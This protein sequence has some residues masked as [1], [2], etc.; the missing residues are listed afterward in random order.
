MKN[1]SIAISIAAFLLAVSILQR[2]FPQSTLLLAARTEEHEAYRLVTCLFIHGSWLHVCVN[3][4]AF[5]ILLLGFGRR[6]STRLVAQ[7]FP[8]AL[9]AVWVYSEMLMPS[10][11]WLCGSSPLVYALFGLIA[12]RERKTSVFSLFGIRWLSLPP[13]PMLAAVLV[14]DAVLSSTCFK[15][16]AWPVHMLSGMGG[17]VTGA[18]LLWIYGLKKENKQ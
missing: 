17:L 1:N 15:F 8:A 3:A 14:C 18:I 4:S 7:A 16:V 12:W 11:A 6:V 13:I 10:R 2:V 9:L 5:I